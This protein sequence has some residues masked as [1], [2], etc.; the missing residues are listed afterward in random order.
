MRKLGAL[1]LCLSVAGAAGEASARRRAAAAD[2]AQADAV[3]AINN[4]GAVAGIAVDPGTGEEIVEAP[5]A[6]PAP[7]LRER[8]RA[9]A[10]GLRGTA[11][12][13]VGPFVGSV[14]GSGV[15]A[16]WE[17]GR[18]ALEGALENAILRD[19]FEDFSRNPLTF[20]GLYYFNPDGRVRFYGLAGAGMAALQVAT[21]FIRLDDFSLIL[22]AGA[23]ADLRISRRFSLEGDLREVVDSRNGLT[24]ALNIGVALRF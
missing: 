18:Y 17:R 2:G 20:S 9:F 1:F 21:P 15:Y 12:G 5:V 13:S 10:V 23:G 4:G 16:R 3:V 24:T 19:S 14:V 22:Q 11:G 8:H 6:Q 7:R